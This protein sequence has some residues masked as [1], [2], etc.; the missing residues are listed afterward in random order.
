VLHDSLANTLY[1]PGVGQ[2]SDGVTQYFHQDELG[3]TRYM[4][5]ANGG[6][7]SLLRYDAFGQRSLTYGPL[8]PS[9]FLYGGG[10]G[11][12]TEY[13]DATEPGLGLQYLAQRYYDPAIGRIVTP[14]PIGLGGALNL[15]LT[16]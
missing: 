1:A 6:E 4:T 5:A 9:E 8:Y 15:Y 7:T 12:Q 10:W 11:Y 14:D 16:P 2:Q 3:S 13:T